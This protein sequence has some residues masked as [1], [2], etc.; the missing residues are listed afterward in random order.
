MGCVTNATSQ[1]CIRKHCM[2]GCYNRGH[3]VT[4]ALL[5]MTNTKYQVVSRLE[6]MLETLTP[7]ILV[8]ELSLHAPLYATLYASGLFPFMP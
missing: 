7:E 6:A 8:F 1:L 3:K 4:I 5:F 2:P